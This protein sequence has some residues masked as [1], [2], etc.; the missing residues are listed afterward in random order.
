MQNILLLISRVSEKDI[1]I[2]NLKYKQIKEKLT[3][4]QN[5]WKQI[6]YFKDIYNYRL[7]DLKKFQKLQ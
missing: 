3:S 7:S 5:R 6:D 4:N 1:E 2:L